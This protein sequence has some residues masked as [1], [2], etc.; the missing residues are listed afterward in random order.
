MD[1]VKDKKR[2]KTKD[3]G[4]KW[5]IQETMYSVAK[6]KIHGKNAASVKIVFAGGGGRG[7]EV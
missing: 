5:K 7:V 6:G 4:K 3:K 2:E 1:M